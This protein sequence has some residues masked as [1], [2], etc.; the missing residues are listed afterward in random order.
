[1]T[2]WFIIYALTAFRISELFVIDDGPF[3]IFLSLRGWANR[4]P[5]DNSLRRN[6]S[7]VLSCVHC[8]GFWVSL[9]F[10]V[11]FYFSNDVT[12]VDAVLFALGVA[13][14]QSL[15]ANKFGRGE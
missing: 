9:L 13:G 12:V 8:F 11:V 15:L 14:F 2:I 5:F 1:M 7:N 4:A 6:L 3:E 10:G